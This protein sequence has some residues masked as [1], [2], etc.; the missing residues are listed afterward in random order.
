MPRRLFA[1]GIQISNI[2]RV[3]NL[4]LQRALEGHMGRVFNNKIWAVGRY[5]FEY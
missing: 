5:T 4:I 1:A 2:C 3:K